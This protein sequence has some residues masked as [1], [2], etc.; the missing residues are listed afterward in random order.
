M[1]VWAS[2]TSTTCRTPLTVGGVGVAL[3]LCRTKASFSNVITVAGNLPRAPAAPFSVSPPELSLQTLWASRLSRG[4]WVDSRPPPHSLSQFTGRVTLC[5]TIFPLPL[6]LANRRIKPTPG[7]LRQRSLYG[8][9]RGEGGGARR[10]FIFFRKHECAL[11]VPVTG[12]VKPKSVSPIHFPRYRSRPP[13]GSDR[14]CPIVFRNL[15]DR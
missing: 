5:G 15:R 1:G 11:C 14:L 10:D 12:L 7:N 6:V 4:L 9:Q 3:T 2:D 13:P 8:N